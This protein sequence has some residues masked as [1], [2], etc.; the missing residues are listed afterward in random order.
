[1]TV[2]SSRKYS[3]IVLD[4]GGVLLFNPSIGSVP[5]SPRLIL[6]ALDS[7]VWHELE[8]DNISETDCNVAV[9]QTF[10]CDLELWIETLSMMR[11]SLRPNTEFI[12]TIR[13]LKEIN[14]R[15]RVL[16]LSNMPSWDYEQLKP[17]LD[18]WGI[19]DGFFTSA[20]LRER[21]PDEIMYKKF[22]EEAGVD[23]ESC[24][25]VDDR[26]ENVVAAHSIGF[27]GIVFD[28]TESATLQLQALFPDPVLRGRSFLLANAKKL[29]CEL[30]TGGHQPDNYSQL[31]ILEH[32]TDRY[33]EYFRVLIS[34][35][36]N[37]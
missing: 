21:K 11:G 4:V 22:Q 6:N 27:Q 15:L 19:F 31:L 36:A 24:V 34:S 33:V 12:Q 1:M 3:T 23:A 25:F 16:G 32:T 14:P 5:V 30:N 35:R 18:E 9:C 8:R 2:T 20:Q 17:T 37:D 7:P 28:D 26:L 29:F 13:C 10:G